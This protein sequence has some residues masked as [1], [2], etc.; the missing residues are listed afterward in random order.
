ML[1]E[2]SLPKKYAS[3][4]DRIRARLREEL[5]L[6]GRLGLAGYF[7]MVW[8]IVQFAQSKGIPTQ[9][10][11]S[12]ANSLVTYLLDITTVDPIAYNLVFARFLNEERSTIPD[13]DLDFASARDVRL[14]DRDDVLNYVQRKYGAD[15]VGLTCTFITFGVKMAIREIGKVFGYPNLCWKQCHASRK[16]EKI[17]NQPLARL[18]HPSSLIAIPNK[19]MAAF[20]RSGSGGNRNAPPRFDPSGRDDNHFV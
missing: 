20:P 15:C 16:D 9:G 8:D 11:G 18:R 2:A 1:C 4:T 12:A 6:I 3:I 17:Q 7:L 10:R 19:Q 5:T 13:I 14:P